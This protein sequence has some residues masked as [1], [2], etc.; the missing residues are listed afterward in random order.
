MQNANPVPSI[1]AE[2]PLARELAL[3]PG[4]FSQACYFGNPLITEMRL[5]NGT[6]TLAT[7]EHRRIGIT[8]A[9]VIQGYRN[10]K[11]TEPELNFYIGTAIIDIESI[12]ISEDEDFDICTISLDDIPEA[13]LRSNGSVETHY[14]TLIPGV[15]PNLS[16]GDFIA[17]G[18]FPGVWR[19]QPAHNE[20]I[21]DTFSTGGTEI[22][23][24]SDRTIRC[25][26]DLENTVMTLAD[27]HASAPQDLGGLSGGPAFK[28]H[29]LESGIAVFPLVGIISEHMQQYDSVLIKRLNCIDSDFNILR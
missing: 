26:L 9:H 23:D 15:L 25:Q 12:I 28:I 29:I 7:D 5:N 14:T 19:Q 22:S 11:V 18:G 3:L 8:N 27:H 20:L 1:R 10:R 16:E 17:F 6:V 13:E 24:I 4:K 2:D 21:F